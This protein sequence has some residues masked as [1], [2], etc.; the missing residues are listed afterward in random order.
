MTDYN[1]Y[2]YL[3]QCNEYFKIGQT[4]DDVKKRLS[5]IQVGCPYDIHL[6]SF[7]ESVDP[8]YDE[9]TIHTKL[10]G[11]KKRGEWYCLPKRIIEQKSEW[12]RPYTFV[13]LENKETKQTNFNLIEKLSTL[14][15]TDIIQRSDDE[16][17]INQHISDAIN[18][19]NYLESYLGI[20]N[21][22]IL[23]GC[24]DKH[25]QDYDKQIRLITGINDK[26]IHEVT[27]REKLKLT[28]SQ[29]AGEL[30]LEED[31]SNGW[32]SVTVA[33]GAGRTALI[34]FN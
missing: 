14:I 9:L 32:Q 4:K 21:Q 23:H 20:H 22:L 25:R 12:F 16:L 24:S 34:P 29:I 31:N 26:Q 7:F 10:A 33:V 19:F 5:S 3:L 17:A 13:S 8:K 27:K 18:H 28:M 1:G 6:I 15:A 2:V 30:A 11:Y